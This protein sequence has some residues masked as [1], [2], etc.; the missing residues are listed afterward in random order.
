MYFAAKSVEYLGHIISEGKVATDPKKIQAVANWPEPKTEKQLR[1][2]L[3]LAGYYRRFIQGYG[4]IA[5]AV[6]L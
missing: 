5:K 3:G 4:P 2:F 6:T 1:A